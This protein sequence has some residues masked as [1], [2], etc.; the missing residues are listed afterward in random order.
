[1]AKEPD[2]DPT[3]TPLNRVVK[4][5]EFYNLATQPSDVMTRADRQSAWGQL[6]LIKKR[7]KYSW[8]NLGF[9][10]REAERIKLNKPDWV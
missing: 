7:A 9:S 5:R 2:Q 6:W 10:D 8:A 4:A 1:M 3:V